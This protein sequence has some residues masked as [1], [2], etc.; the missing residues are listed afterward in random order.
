M[1]GAAYADN[2][3]SSLWMVYAQADKRWA[4]ADLTVV[5][6]ELLTVLGAGPLALWIC[7]GI[8]QRDYRV[9]FWMVV[10]ATAELYG[11]AF[12]FSSLSL[13]FFLYFLMLFSIFSLMYFVFQFLYFLHFLHFLLL[14]PVYFTFSCIFVCEWVRARDMMGTMLIY[15]AK[16]GFMTFAPEWLTGNPNLDSSNFMFLWVYLVF[17]NMIWVFM[18]LYALWVA[19]ADISNAFLVRNGVMAARVELE[20]RE[21]EAKEE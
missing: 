11:G 9:A 6:L 13:V 1:F 17:F 3:A 12:G 5:S 18:P 15:I 8:S 7:F 20:R 2:W 16:T 4:G 14:S 19:F 21:K 10:L